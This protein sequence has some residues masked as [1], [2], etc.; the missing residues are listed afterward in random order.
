MI[1]NVVGK[2]IPL[3]GLMCIYFVLHVDPRWTKIGPLWYSIL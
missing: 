2:Y 3:V 1:S